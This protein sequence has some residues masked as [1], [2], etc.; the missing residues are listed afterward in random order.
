MVCSVPDK[1]NRS[2]FILFRLY[3]ENFS[4][5]YEEQCCCG[6]IEDNGYL[7]ANNRISFYVLYVIPHVKERV[8][9]HKPSPSFVPVSSRITYCGERLMLI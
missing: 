6:D 5:I 7:T 2:D 8:L 4:C 9:Y 1:S 3:D